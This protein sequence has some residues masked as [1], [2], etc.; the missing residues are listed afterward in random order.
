[1]PARRESRGSCCLH[2][3]ERD[4]KCK[5]PMFP[6]QSHPPVLYFGIYK[7]AVEGAI[8]Q[9]DIL[10]E[11]IDIVRKEENRRAS[12]LTN[13]NPDFA[14]DQWSFTHEPF[15]NELCLL[16]LVGLRHQVE[17][18]L[19]SLAARAADDGKDIADQTYNQRVTEL[20]GESNTWKL[21]ESRLGLES[22]KEWKIM[23][24]LRHLSNSYKH[25]FSG[26]PSNDLLKSLKLGTEVNY[27]P[28]P[29]SQAVK[30][31][32]ARYIGLQD[33]ASYCDISQR[34]VDKAMEF[35][36]NVQKRNRLSNVRRKPVS[37]KPK[38]FLH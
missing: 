5:T 19:L 26:A 18:A 28:L 9:S 33:N 15:V 24:L 4:A 36:D 13:D 6:C 27:A 32:I 7:N 17:R 29:E 10:R 2:E 23:Q 34:F 37:L 25:D 31:S 8:M 16:L 3:F 14:Y 1:M 12:L 30:E 20:K 35:L 22:C 11:M 21:I 38:T